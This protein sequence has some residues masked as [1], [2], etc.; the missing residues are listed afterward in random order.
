MVKRVTAAVQLIPLKPVDMLLAITRM[1]YVAI[2]RPK[3]R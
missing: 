3:T 1:V 2:V